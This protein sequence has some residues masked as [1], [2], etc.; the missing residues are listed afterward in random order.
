MTSSLR[1]LPL[2]HGVAAAG[3]IVVDN[4]SAWRKDA[5]KAARQA[6]RKAARPGA[7]KAEAAAKPGARPRRKPAAG[8]S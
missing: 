2:R 7:A 8:K 5:E 1:R 3:A 4:S 6:A